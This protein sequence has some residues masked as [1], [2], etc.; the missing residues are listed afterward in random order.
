MTGVLVERRER[1]QLW[2][3]LVVLQALQVDVA[4]L[5]AIIMIPVVQQ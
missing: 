5:L 2:L 1:W 4:V 3:L